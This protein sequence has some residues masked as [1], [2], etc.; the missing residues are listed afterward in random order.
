MKSHTVRTYDPLVNNVFIRLLINQFLAG[1]EEG[2]TLSI[3]ESVSVLTYALLADSEFEI[4]EDVLEELE[5]IVNTLAYSSS[6]A[7]KDDH[8]V[9]VNWLHEIRTGQASKTNSMIP[10]P[11]PFEWDGE[12]AAM[13]CFTL[14]RWAKDGSTDLDGPKSPER[15][16]LRNAREMFNAFAIGQLTNMNDHP[17]MDM[18]Y[19]EVVQLFAVKRFIKARMQPNNDE[20][21]EAIKVLMLMSQ[22]WFKLLNG[23]S[24]QLKTNLVQCVSVEITE[25]DGTAPAK[26]LK[27]GV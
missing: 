10:T 26:P 1:K 16:F 21:F 4:T 19:I 8:A 20:A 7:I 3:E 24:V 6:K 23:L 5:I 22:L 14:L 9:A 15:Q 13:G 27:S 12:D 17:Y 2:R 18:E 11:A 25:K